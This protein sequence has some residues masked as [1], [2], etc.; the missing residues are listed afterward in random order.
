MVEIIPAPMPKSFKEL[1][2]LVGRVH[3][4]AKKIQVDVVDGRFAKHSWLHP[5]T[6]PYT[7]RKSFDIIVEKEHGLPFWQE[8]T[9]EFDLM[10]QNPLEEMMNFVHAGGTHI[11]VHASAPGA[12]E[13]L[14]KLADQR[15]NDDGAFTITTGVALLPNMQPDVLEHFDALYDYVQV[16]GIN[17]I[18]R[19]GSAFEPQSLALIERLRKRYP[20][21]A[22][23]VDGGVTT[24]TALQLVQAGA[25]RLVVGHTI[26]AADNPEEAYQTLYNM[27]NVSE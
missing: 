17:R 27:V 15:E 4:F 18:G 2:E 14:Q 8:I 16:M 22:I 13:A 24:E 23:Q 21:L 11:I 3:G 9:Y 25:S 7:D 1:E 20:D 26:L 19:Q 12:A 5:K 10:I 6:W